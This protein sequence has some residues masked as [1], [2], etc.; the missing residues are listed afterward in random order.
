MV[1]DHGSPWSLWVT[2]DRCNF[3]FAPANPLHSAG[4][5]G[6]LRSAEGKVFLSAVY[7]FCS[8]Q[9]R[10][11][12]HSTL[13]EGMLSWYSTLGLFLVLG[14]VNYVQVL[15]C[16]FLAQPCSLQQ[17]LHCKGKDH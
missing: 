16:F 4:H 9:R 14:L 12:I 3:R 10:R 11:S 8:L 6:T 2:G 15:M 13:Q 1:F 17:C 7:T 5:L